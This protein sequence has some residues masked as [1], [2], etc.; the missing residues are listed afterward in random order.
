MHGILAF[1][2]S[3]AKQRLSFPQHKVARYQ[4]CHIS[5]NYKHGNP[6][7]KS[8]N[9]KQKL[10]FPQG[11]QISG[12]PYKSK[13]I[14]TSSLHSIISSGLANIST[15]KC[16]QMAGLPYKSKSICP[17]SSHS[18]YSSAHIRASGVKEWK[19]TEEGRNNKILSNVEKWKK[20]KVKKCIDPAINFDTYFPPPLDKWFSTRT[21]SRPVF[22][23][24]FFLRPVIEDL[25]FNFSKLYK[26]GKS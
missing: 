14:A 24:Y 4:G 9:A 15:I 20:K 25:Q 10:T 17:E 11:C 6:A 7:F 23:V 26:V 22:F 19:R 13:Y 18:I 1:K 5:P 16:C 21:V 2:S 8:S 12:L 3:N